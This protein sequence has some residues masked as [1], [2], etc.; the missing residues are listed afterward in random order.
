[1]YADAMRSDVSNF[2]VVQGCE[3]FPCSSPYENG[4]RTSD[5]SIDLPPAPPLIDVTMFH[6]PNPICF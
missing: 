5:L 2:S 4:C 1:M 3:G 6:I